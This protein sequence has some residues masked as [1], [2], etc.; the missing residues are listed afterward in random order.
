[1]LPLLEAVSC[2][3]ARENFPPDA[4]TVSIIS[5][6]FPLDEGNGPLHQ[7]NFPAANGGIDKDVEKTSGS[8]FGGEGL[9][10][11]HGIRHVVQH[12]NAVDPVKLPV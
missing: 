7:G 9:D 10:A 3:E 8:E 1:M 12:A 6:L 11:T 5:P 2:G 4:D